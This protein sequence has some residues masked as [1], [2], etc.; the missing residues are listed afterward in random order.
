MSKR[1]LARS[2]MVQFF[3]VTA[4]VGSNHFF[5]FL[6]QIHWLLKILIEIE[7]YHQLVSNFI[8]KIQI[9]SNPIY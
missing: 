7:I 8:F 1:Y 4:R 6:I 9:Q 5:N 2:I 3:I